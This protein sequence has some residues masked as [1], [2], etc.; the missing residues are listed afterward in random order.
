MPFDMTEEEIIANLTQLVLPNDYHFDDGKFIISTP[1]SF[2]ESKALFDASEEVRAQ[3]FRLLQDDN[4]LPT[5]ANDTLRVKLYGSQL[6]YQSFNGILFD[7]NFPNSG[8][9][10]IEDFGTFYTYQR[11]PE[12]STYTVEEL[13]RH[14]FVHYLQGRFIIPGTWAGSPYYDNNR[15]VWFEEGMAQFLTASTKL[16]GVKGL[17]VVRNR[18]QSTGN[19][20]TL[21]DVFN[22]SYSSGNQDAFYI[23]GAMLWRWWYDSDKSLIKQLMDNLRNTQ[24]TQFDNSVNSIRNSAS[25]NNQFHSFINQKLPLQD[26]WISPQT[27][28]VDQV[29]VD[30]TN[31]STLESEVL[32]ADPSVSVQSVVFSGPEEE[33]S[34]Q[35]SGQL[36]LTA[37]N[38]NQELSLIHI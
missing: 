9:I 28:F 36:N 11:T 14:E 22:S 31:A 29:D 16:E 2:E 38:N 21:T 27:D 15:L 32:S 34:F 1:L 19:F 17:Q 24:L 13:F 3:F 6:D 20:Q 30:F 25:Q 26:F 33:R 23:Y 37:A 7:I 18:I 35:L 8:G 10:Y 4:P 12:Q 5:D